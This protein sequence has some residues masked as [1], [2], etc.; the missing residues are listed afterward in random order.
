M[1][2]PVL[3]AG[4]YYKTFMWPASFWEKVYERTIRRAAGLGRA[5]GAPDPDSYDRVS[6]HCDVLVVGGGPAGLMAALVAGRAGA[7]VLLADEDFA[8]GGQSLSD[9][10]PADTAELASLPNVTILPRTTVF[11]VYDGEYGAV[12]RVADHLAEPPPFTPRQRLWRI[13][14]RR[15]VLAAGAVER[16]IA[17]GANDLPGVMLA[18]AVRR[19]VNR[20]A[21]RPGQR[22]VLFANHDGAAQTAIDLVA[23]GVTIAAIVDPRAAS[24]ALHDAAERTGASLMTGSVVYDALGRHAVTAVQAGPIGGPARQNIECDLVAVSGG[25]NPTLHL[26]THLGGK[27]VF[28]DAIAAFVPGPSLPP[29][30]AVAGAASGSFGPGDALAE[31]ARLGAEAAEACGFHATIPN[32]PAEPGAAPYGIEPLWR[33]TGARR[34]AFVDFQNDVTDTDVELA[35]R[36]G[37]RAAEHMKRYTTLGMATDQG[38]TSGVGGIAIMA[39]LTGR[40]IGATG[41]TTARPPYTPVTLGALAG[42]H[43]GEHFRPTRLPPA[44]DWAAARGAE[45]VPAGAWLRAAYYPQP[46]EDWLAAATREARAV[47]ESAGFCDVSTLGKIDVQG[48]DAAMFLDRV[49]ANTFSTLRPGRVRYGLMLR[50]DG[51]VFDDGTVACLAP[52][53]YV[54]TTTTAQA[55]AV[56]R[57]LELCRQWLFPDLDVQLASVTEQWAQL[58]VAGPRSRDVLAGIVDPPF[59]IGPGAFPFM[60]AAELTV[61][62]GVPARLFRLSFSGELAYEIAVPTRYGAALAARL[63]E[64]AVPY[65]LE[66]LAC[67]GSRRVTRRAAS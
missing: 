18:G 65:G 67:C 53:R 60:E 31:G 22:A 19:Y 2:S 26:S 39:E 54:M 27:P 15:C 41:T 10:E 29:G 33:V 64:H 20:W 62:G 11:G 44:H 59:D 8:L 30:M 5:A 24:P 25:W 38:K 66:A 35:H 9:A 51:F 16:P 36:E 1:A 48:P 13:V 14:A 47:R 57:H 23:A 55:G 12:E 4:F 6:A 46:G 45:F 56:L 7:R 52:G 50:E 61:C 34:K 42:P 40:S 58:S 43:R 37:F 17:F 49:Y 32:S 28:R 3:A 21:V 63:A